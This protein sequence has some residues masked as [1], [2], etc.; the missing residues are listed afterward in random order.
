MALLVGSGRGD[1]ASP[2]VV[3]NRISEAT[4]EKILAECWRL[5]VLI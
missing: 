2:S 5:V 1:V 3:L 4:L